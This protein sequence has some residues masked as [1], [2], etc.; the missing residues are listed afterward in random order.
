MWFTF[1]F[2]VFL[3]WVFI[4]GA[5]KRKKIDVYSYTFDL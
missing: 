2:F 1:N 3:F 5:Y 4:W